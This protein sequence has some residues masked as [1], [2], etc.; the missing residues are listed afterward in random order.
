MFERRRDVRYPQHVQRLS[1]EPFGDKE[2]GIR[3][4]SNAVARVRLEKHLEKAARTLAAS[5]SHE[6]P[7]SRKQK[8]SF[9]FSHSVI[10]SAACRG[11][12]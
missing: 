2:I 3:H 1:R 11:R 7:R 12:S 5:M 10:F 4:G 8:L 9:L 6:Q